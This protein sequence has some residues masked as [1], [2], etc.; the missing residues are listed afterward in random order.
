MPGQEHAWDE[1]NFPYRA[2]LFRGNEKHDPYFVLM[3]ER[4]NYYASSF[5]DS[6]FC[7]LI[8]F[9]GTQ[10]L[11]KP[12]LRMM[13]TK[14]DPPLA[15]NACF[16][17]RDAES[18]IGV[19]AVSRDVCVVRLWGY[20]A[21]LMAREFIPSGADW[22]TMNEEDWNELEGQESLDRQLQW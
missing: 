20:E 21:D 3:D 22:G 11:T 4:W 17:K 15:A 16:Q 10:E 13:E 1:K 2:V 19:V 18:E 12:E 14:A 5:E 9:A 8:V 7:H 6:V